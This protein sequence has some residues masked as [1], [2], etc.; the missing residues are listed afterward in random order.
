MDSWLKIQWFELHALKAVV[1]NI[2]FSLI[3]KHIGFFY[4]KYQKVK[5]LWRILKDFF[6]CFADMY[7]IT[8]LKKFATIHEPVL[9]FH[10]LRINQTVLNM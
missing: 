7:I 1:Q 4:Q 3:Y 5:K 10:S 6:L 8:R 9:I 2:S